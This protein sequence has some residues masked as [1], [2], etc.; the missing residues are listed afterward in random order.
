MEMEVVVVVCL[1]RGRRNVAESVTCG[2][3]SDGCMGVHT[4]VSMCVCM[5]TNHVP[6]YTVLVQTYVHMFMYMYMYVYSIHTR[7]Q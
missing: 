4:C 2:L 5:Y 1:L 7:V 3:D 6:V